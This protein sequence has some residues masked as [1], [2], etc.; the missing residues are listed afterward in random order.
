MTSSSSLSTDTFPVKFFQDPIGSLYVKLLTN[1]QTL[2]ITYIL[3][4]VYVYH[5]ELRTE[6][7]CTQIGTH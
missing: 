2:G 5:N 3:G 1:K 7:T 4:R 6:Y